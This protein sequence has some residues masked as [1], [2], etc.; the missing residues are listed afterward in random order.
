[1][2]R[3]ILYSHPFASYCQ[4]ALIA[5]YEL[6]IEF[7]QVLIE[8]D[9]GRATLAEL[10]PPATMPI[11]R[12]GDAVVPESTLV[13]EYIDDGRLIPDLQARLWDRFSDQYVMNQMQAIVADTFEADAVALARA[14]RTLDMAY[15]VL[16]ERLDTNRW[17]AGDAFTIADCAIAPALFYTRAVYRWAD[18]QTNVD[19]YYR[20]LAARP[21]V[22]RVIDEARPYRNLFPLPWPDDIDG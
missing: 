14:N 1:M 2:P 21:S 11:L 22:A 9:E 16:E 10:W 8:G 5:L 18:D 15:G 19:D 6:G 13:I 17:L 3:V 12:D 4:K 20:R 7:E